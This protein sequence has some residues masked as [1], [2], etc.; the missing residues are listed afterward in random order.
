MQYLVSWVLLTL[1]WNN[2]IQNNKFD[3][4]DAFELLYVKDLGKTIAQQGITQN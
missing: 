1:A 3:L 2:D 4:F